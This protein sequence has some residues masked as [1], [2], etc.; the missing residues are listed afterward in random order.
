[1]TVAAV[2]WP[3]VR[4]HLRAVRRSHGGPSLRRIASVVYEWLLYLFVA[5]GVVVASLSHT[6]ASFTPPTTGTGW[7]LAVAAVPA[8]VAAV[9]SVSLALG[10]LVVGPSVAYWLLATPVA[11]RDLLAPRAAAVGAGTGAV[12][13]GALAL[14]AV[15]S[16]VEAWL[17]LTAAAGATGVLLAGMCVLAQTGGRTA[18]RGVR[19]AVRAVLLVSLLAVAVAV[20]AARAGTVGEA[21]APSAPGAWTAAGA[22]ALGAVAAWAAAWRR[23]DRAPASSLTGGASLVGA[24]WA[25]VAG[26]DLG[27]ASGVVRDRQLWRRAVVRSR[28]RRRPGRGRALLAANAR[29]A[30]RDPTAL[31]WA[32]GLVLVPY[33]AALLVP[34]VVVPVVQLAGA[35]AVAGLFATSLRAVTG[36]AALRRS[37][38]GRDRDLTAVLCVVPLAAAVV[39]SLLVA[40]AGGS[41]VSL[42]LLPA[43]ALAVVVRHAT[44][45]PRAAT[46]TLYE[47]PMGISIPVELVQDL[48]RGPALF[49]VLAAVALVTG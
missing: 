5:G 33:V 47:T 40:P 2:P 8:A 12:A 6:V 20:M 37:L 30:L 36:S 19:A 17:P 1:M 14:V 13:A 48:S 25:G 4:R 23:L 34:P 3:P 41:A 46:V 38:G 16:G 9:A 45:P 43:S 29:I 18:A 22:V 7:W 24:L 39:W 10:P 44:R 21:G 11:R 35:T 32:A 28:R 31:A 26:M 15:S 42:A 49:V 27:L